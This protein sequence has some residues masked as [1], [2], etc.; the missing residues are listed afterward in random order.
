MNTSISENLNIEKR[1][2]IVNFIT[3]LEGK[4]NVKTQININ[5]P[6]EKILEK[7]FQTVDQI[8]FNALLS[9]KQEGELIL[10]YRDER[11]SRQ[12]EDESRIKKVK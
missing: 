1:Q 5:W 8:L 7:I 6:L 10:K 11:L 3:K 2:I 12:E 9:S 4:Y